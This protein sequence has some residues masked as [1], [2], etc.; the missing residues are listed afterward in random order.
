[1][2]CSDRRW[3]RSRLIPDPP[4]ASQHQLSHVEKIAEFLSAHYQDELTVHHIAANVNL[5]PNYAMD[6][7][8]KSFG[9]TIIEYLTTLRVAH[10]Q[11]LLVNTDQSVLT[12]ALES[13]FG[14]V[15][16]FYVAFNRLC[17]MS[18]RAYRES[19]R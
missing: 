5:H 8:R 13:G 16:Q 18:P 3:F 4:N 10:A 1:M 12:I 9:A 15:S 2:S 17:G 14:S 7:F 6:I 11:Q 19:L